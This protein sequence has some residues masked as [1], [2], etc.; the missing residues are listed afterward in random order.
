[1]MEETLGNVAPLEHWKCYQIKKRKDL[2]VL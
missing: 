2:S 1:M